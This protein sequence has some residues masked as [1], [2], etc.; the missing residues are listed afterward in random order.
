MT[1]WTALIG[2]SG[3]RK[4]PAIDVVK[5]TLDAIESENEPNVDQMRHQHKARIEQSKQDLKRWRAERQKAL[6]AKPPREPPPMPTDL[7]DK[8]PFI[9]PRLY[10]TDSTSIKLA[11]LLTV[12]PRG[13]MLIRDE[14]SGLFANME[15]YGDRAFWLEA[16]NGGRHNV[17]RAEWSVLVP[18]LLVGIVG[19]FQPDKLV[20]AFAGDEDGMYGRLLYGWPLLPDYSPLTDDIDEVDTAFKNMLTHLIRLS[21]E[22]DH[23][24]FTP[25]SVP[26]SQ[27]ALS[28]FEEYRQLV[29]KTKRGLDGREQHWFAKSESQ[30]LRLAGT[31]AYIDWAA[32]QESSSSGGIEQITG[33]L[34]PSEIGERFMIGAICLVRDY[35][36]PHARAALRQ[37]GLTDRHRHM[38]RVL[39]WLKIHHDG[40]PISLK[41]IRREALGGS[42]DAEQTEDLLDRL[43]QA[44]WLRRETKETGG[45]PIHRWVVNPQLRAPAGTAERARKGQQ[46]GFGAVPAIRAVR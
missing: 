43:E 18:H 41:D 8:G 31:L 27:A 19:G 35:F 23:Q 16:W 11:E 17:E 45:R 6:K 40:R 33:R 42:L 37:V 44:G 21:A 3:G 14:L 36:W 38:R 30:V 46:P 10:T 13:L 22:N 7:V 24:Q 12:R 39:R 15:R 32:S 26:L 5:R 9:Y 2:P 29:D 20:R 25:Q 1:L 34:E 28:R 4:T